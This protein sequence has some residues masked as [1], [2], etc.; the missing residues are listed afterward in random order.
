MS[1]KSDKRRARREHW[2]QMRAAHKIWCRV[3]GADIPFEQ[4]LHPELRA[5][6]NERYAKEH[7]VMRAVHD[8]QRPRRSVL[9]RD[10]LA[11][12]TRSG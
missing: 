5:A 11:I 2:E 9:E 1:D 12:G 3:V 6:A 4:W 10:F 7:G 8:Q